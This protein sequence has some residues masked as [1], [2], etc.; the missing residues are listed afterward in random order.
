MSMTN[1]REYAQSIRSAVKAAVRQAEDNYANIHIPTAGQ[2]GA[3]IG[4]INKIAGGDDNRKLMLGWLFAKEDLFDRISTKTLTDEQWAALY[5]WC[6]FRKDE[7]RIIWMP[8]DTFSQECLACLSAA[9][10]DY[11]K[12]RYSERG[13]LPEPPEIVAELVHDLG[14]EVTTGAMAGVRVSDELFEHENALPTP[15][16]PKSP[17]VLV[18]PEKRLS[19]EEAIEDLGFDVPKRAIKPVFQTRPRLIN[20]FE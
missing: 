16:T 13:D 12:V 18:S 15:D 7:D 1:P 19:T 5:A 8:K 6:D 4:V 14:G 17:Y 11:F 9:M 10:D 20:P 2:R 3:V